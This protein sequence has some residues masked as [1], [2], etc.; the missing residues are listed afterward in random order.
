MEKISDELKHCLDNSG[1]EECKYFE[2]RSILTCRSLLQIAYDRI[3]FYEDLEEQGKL[4]RLPCKVGKT[5]YSLVCGE[6]EP[7]VVASFKND[8]EYL[9]FINR[10]GGYIGVYGTNVFLTKEE[11]EAALKGM[12]AKDLSENISETPYNGDNIGGHD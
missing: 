8:G 1:C 12:K 5:V 10:L 3:K 6:I 9:W 2:Q 4:V 7:E 11:A